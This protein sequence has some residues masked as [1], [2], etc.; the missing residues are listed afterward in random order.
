VTDTLAPV[1]ARP[2][3]SAWF[4]LVGAVCVLVLFGAGG[5]WLDPN[6]PGVSVNLKDHLGLFGVGIM[7]AALVLCLSRPRLRVD[8]NGVDA[9]G[10]FGGWRH[11]DWDLV[12]SVEFPPKARFARL[13]L[14]GDE[15][16]ALYAV[17]RGDRERSV[18]VMD[19]LRAWHRQ[20]TGDPAGHHTSGDAPG[21]RAPGS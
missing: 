18:L 16:I 11:I 9:R 12:V 13:V 6:T 21:N 5:I 14:P 1:S 8:G 19:Q 17:Q 20:A 3:R 10:F 2:V 7:L 15:I 4:A